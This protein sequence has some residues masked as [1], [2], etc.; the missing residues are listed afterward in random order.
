MRT[1]SKRKW[2]GEDK[3]KGKGRGRR[4]KRNVMQICYL[5]V[6]QEIPVAKGQHRI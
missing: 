2:E 3:D 4:R 6:R 1:A 5:F